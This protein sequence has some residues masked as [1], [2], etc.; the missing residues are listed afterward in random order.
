MFSFPVFASK[1]LERKCLSVV[2]QVK[3]SEAMFYAEALVGGCKSA[4]IPSCVHMGMK[5][6]L[7]FA[8]Q[9]IETSLLF[10]LVVV[11]V[12]WFSWEILG[13]DVLLPPAATPDAMT[14]MTAATNATSSAPATSYCRYCT[15]IPTAI[16]TCTST[17]TCN[18]LSPKPGWL[19]K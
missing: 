7:G 12:F 5:V 4:W 17:C 16:I 8:G 9:G 15:A 11:F 6:D 3:R 10:L 18:Y 19:S 1:V 14:T 2:L 13:E